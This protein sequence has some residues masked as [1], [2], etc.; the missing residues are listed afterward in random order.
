MPNPYKNLLLLSLIVCAFT[1]YVYAEDASTSN[2]A[3]NETLD[4]VAVSEKS[5]AAG[6]GL[7]RNGPFSGNP[8]TAGG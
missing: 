5:V 6:C 1:S 4:N 3:T 8:Y 7:G 2:V